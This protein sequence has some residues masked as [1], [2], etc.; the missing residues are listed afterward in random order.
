MNFLSLVNTAI[1]ESKQ[2]LD[3]LSPDTFDNPGRTVLYDRLK[4]WVSRSYQELVEERREWFFTNERGVATVRPR[5]HLV[6][7]DPMYIP[8]EGDTMVGAYSGVRFAIVE[9]D[10]GHE[11]Y[12]D[13]EVT[14]GVAFDNVVDMNA[15]R[16]GE[17]LEAYSGLDVFPLAAKVEAR[18]TYDMSFYLPNLN[19]INTNT[20]TIQRSVLDPDYAN[21][22]SSPAPPLS[23]LPWP[24]WAKRYNN[25]YEPLGHPRFVTT[26][27]SGALQFYPHPDGPY[28]VAFEYA[29]K[30]S[31]LID[32]EDVPTVIPEKHH[33]VLV[34]M[35]LRELADFNN[36]RALFSR[37]NKK[38]QE[39]MSW[40]MRDNLPV[41]KMDTSLYYRGLY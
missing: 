40:L 4:G 34:W 24:E 27:N 25:F 13:M 3:K 5:L 7:T 26:T 28:D 17:P 30:A 20:I 18:G 16:Q 29:Q 9:I 35:A 8:Q 23:Y 10:G 33:M 6:I 22:M 41:M 39:R 1:E 31:P 15:L 36:D 11:G 2:S 21:E 37:A 12:S 14:V 38:Y 32:W 19:S